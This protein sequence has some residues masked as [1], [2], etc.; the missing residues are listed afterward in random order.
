[1]QP[2]IKGLE[3]PFEKAQPPAKNQKQQP[4]QNNWAQSKS[5][6]VPKIKKKMKKKW[7]I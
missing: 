5:G 7:R 4:T 6:F 2:K 1:V 3:N